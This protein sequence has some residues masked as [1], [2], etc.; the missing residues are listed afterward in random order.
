M[1]NSVWCGEN[2]LPG[3]QGSYSV[4]ASLPEVDLVFDPGNDCMCTVQYFSTRLF[5]VVKK[6][7]M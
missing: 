5:T 7:L 3:Q 2:H 1:Y 6:E 4:E